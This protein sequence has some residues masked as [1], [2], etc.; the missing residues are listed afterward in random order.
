MQYI[1]IEREGFSIMERDTRIGEME[2]QIY[3]Y[4]SNT[5]WKGLNWCQLIQFTAKHL[6]SIQL[7]L[8]FVWVQMHIYLYEN[9][10][11]VNFVIN[12]YRETNL[13]R[14]IV[15]RIK[16]KRSLETSCFPIGFV[17]SL[18]CSCEWYVAYYE[19]QWNEERFS[20]KIIWQSHK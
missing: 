7:N 10:T 4:R 17:R 6:N 14:C 8:L 3:I 16:C 1:Y 15:E 5:M 19:L 13:F 20:I 9:V 18:S 12:H 2:L 11:K